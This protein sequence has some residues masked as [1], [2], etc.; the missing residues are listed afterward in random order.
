MKIMNLI[1]L[2][3]LSASSP[4]K[5]TQPI[6]MENGLAC[7][8]ESYF[9]QEVKAENSND[10]LGL[11]YLFKQGYCIMAKQDFPISILSRPKLGVVKIRVYHNNEGIELWTY[12]EHINE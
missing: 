2:I 4:A 9:D 5:A 7:I 3:F 12:Q 10:K 8:S 11:A 1:L 6:L